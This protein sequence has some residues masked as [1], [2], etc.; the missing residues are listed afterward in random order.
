VRRICMLSAGLP[1]EAYML[2]ILADLLVH[3][4]TDALANLTQLLMLATDLASCDEEQLLLRYPELVDGAAY[5]A[6]VSEVVG[7][8]RR[9]AQEVIGIVEEHFHATARLL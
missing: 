5:G 4:D 9:F 3:Q 1:N 7:M 2:D 6:P 8:Y